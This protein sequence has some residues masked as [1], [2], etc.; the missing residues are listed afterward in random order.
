MGC[1]RRT[2]R[3]ET[4][5]FIRRVCS[6]VEGSRV[7]GGC[8]WLGVWF[9]RRGGSGTKIKR[10]MRNH[11]KHLGPS[12]SLGWMVMVPF[13][14]GNGWRGYVSGRRQRDN[15]NKRFCPRLH[16]AASL[17]T[18]G[19]QMS[20]QM[21][22][23]QRDH[24]SLLSLSSS[25]SSSFSLNSPIIFHP[26]LVCP[27]LWCITTLFPQTVSAI[28]T[29]NSFF[30]MLQVPAALTTPPVMD[31]SRKLWAK[32][33]LSTLLCYC[34]GILLLQQETKPRWLRQH[35]A[36]GTHTM[37]P[38]AG[39]TQ[40]QAASLVNIAH[41]KIPLPIFSPATDSHI[42]PKSW[43]RLF[44]PAR[45]ELGAR[46]SFIPYSPPLTDQLLSDNTWLHCTPT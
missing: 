19:P 3:V 12:F 5:R 14:C 24:P 40:R 26:R 11:E 9:R 4:G 15:K 21:S 10:E 13:W 29:A 18:F 30:V 27:Y 16:V 36:S 35:S 1:G 20:A 33:A 28:R 32:E 38:A 45:W 43:G 25:T 17:L 39:A 7:E 2:T 37:K 46:L 44:I 42:I 22:P 8:F 23:P 31:H 41:Q 6:R 34:Q